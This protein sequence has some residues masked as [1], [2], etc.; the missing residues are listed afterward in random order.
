MHTADDMRTTKLKRVAS[1]CPISCRVHAI[2]NLY[3]SSFLPM[4]MEM[5]YPNNGDDDDDDDDGGDNG[6]MDS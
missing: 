1:I 4:C 3:A 6:K 2:F 5:Y